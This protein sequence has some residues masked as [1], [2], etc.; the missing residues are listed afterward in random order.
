M[1]SIGKKRTFEQLNDATTSTTNNDINWE[2][3]I[4]EATTT[5]PQTPEAK[6]REDEAVENFRKLL[7]MQSVLTR[8]DQ[9]AK[10]FRVSEVPDSK[11]FHQQADLVTS[12]ALKLA[13]GAFFGNMSPAMPIQVPVVFANTD[14]TTER[15]S[16]RFWYQ[17]E[18]DQED[19]YTFEEMGGSKFPAGQVR[20]EEQEDA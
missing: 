6:A 11:T 17:T 12:H 16:S 14:F 9:A 5:E 15:E 4:Q 20:H 10:R 18:L 7:R 1:S 19:T 8:M 13:H 3:A 2:S